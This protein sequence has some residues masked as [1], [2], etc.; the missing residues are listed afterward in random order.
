MLKNTTCYLLFFSLV[1]LTNSCATICGGSKYYAHILVN[2]HPHADIVY[3]GMKMGNGSAS[4]SVP[5][6]EADM[7]S[8]TVKE[9]GCAEQTFSYRTRTFRGWAF[10]GTLVTWTGESGGIPLPYGIVI[11][12]ITGAL[13]KPNTAEG[14]VKH[15]YKNFQYIANY[16]GC[17]EDQRSSTIESDKL[18]DVVY[19]KNGSI[20]RGNVIE[21]EPATHIKI[22]T[23]DGSIFVYKAE[24]IL[25]ITRE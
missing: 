13:W 15:N 25:K 2:G 24:E 9:K 18:V 12:L 7:F 19:L 4:I 16:T 23:K 6:R 22:Q 11:D 14:I 1:I 21:N 20:I 17:G 8:F 3:R 5:R 10:V